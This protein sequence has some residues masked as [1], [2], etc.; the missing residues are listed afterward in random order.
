MSSATYSVSAED[1]T[2]KS[3]KSNTP[4]KTTYR[5]AIPKAIENFDPIN[6]EGQFNSQV[7]SQIYS[8]LVTYRTQKTDKNQSFSDIVPLISEEWNISSDR[9]IYNFKIRN[10]VLFHNGRNMTAY[11]IKHTFERLASTKVLPGAQTWIFKDVPIKGLEKYRRDTK[12]NVKD[13]DLSGIK[14]IDDYIV[15]FELTRSTPLF[16]KSLA[17][18]IFSIIPKEEVDKWGKEFGNR[19]VG[20]GPYK[21]EKIT[22]DQIFLTKNENYFEKDLPKIDS[23]IYKII[24]QVNEEYRQFRLGRLEQTA[25]PDSE[26]DRLLQAENLNKYNI[27]V[28]DNNSFN[29]RNVSDIIKEP[30]LI[31]TFL[32][33]SNKNTMLKPQKVRHALN[34]SINKKKIISN[35]LKYKAIESYGIIPED[36]PGVNGGRKTPYPFDMVKAKKL[37]YESGFNDRNNDGVLEYNKKPATLNFWYYDDPETEK[38]C[39]AISEN[40]QAVGFK[41]N[42]QK[43]TNWRD[44]LAKIVSGRADIYHFSWKAKYDDLDKYL[45]PMFDSNFIGSSNIS[46]FSDKEID[47]MLSKARKIPEEEYRNRIYNEADKKIVEKAPWV[48]LYQPVKYVR[49]KPYVYGM[50]IHPVMQDVLK[51][52]YFKKNDILTSLNND[53]R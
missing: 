5:L 7:I 13:P 49:V 24:P 19:P 41:V 43:T 50:Q 29:D 40:L 44:F 6:S 31:N 53:N 33:I 27:N 1:N 52:T 12:N 8:T 42:L 30:R 20:T 21:I 37:F 25:I 17:M 18:P 34:Y 28:F 36:F 11:D 16:L 4:E 22:A 2:G 9:K 26:I 48:F 15:Q 35:V 10:D 14:V 38:V 51:Y 46:S 23:L 47:S 45:T 39:N 3:N 32:G